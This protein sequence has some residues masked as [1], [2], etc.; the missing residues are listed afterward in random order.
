MRHHEQPDNYVEPN[1]AAHYGAS[2][3][4]DAYEAYDAYDAYDR[5]PEPTPWY[6]RPPALVAA[7]AIGMVVLA[8]AAYGLVTLAGGGS[9]APTSTTTT[10]AAS[11]TATTT[12]AATTTTTAARTTETVTESA[13]PE[14]PAWSTDTGAP[15][16]PTTLDPGT[17]TVPSNPV[18]VTPSTPPQHRH[19]DGDG[20]AVTPKLAATLLAG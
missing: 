18:T 20:H 10:P 11:T 1:Q 6:R 7:G 8:L 4:Y 5:G 15:T 16:I 12:M 2:D 17:S 14:T 13:P 19:S 9:K 3:S